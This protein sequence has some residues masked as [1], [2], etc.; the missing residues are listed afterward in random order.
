MRHAFLCEPRVHRARLRQRRALLLALGL[1]ILSGLAMSGTTHA[2]SPERQ[3]FSKPD[4]SPSFMPET[5][6]LRIEE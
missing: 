3:G 2:T 1:V 6:R 4:R 5:V